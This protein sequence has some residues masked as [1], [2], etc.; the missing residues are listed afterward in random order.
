MHWSNQTGQLVQPAAVVIVA[1]APLQAAAYVGAILVRLRSN[2]RRVEDLGSSER[3]RLDWLR[4]LTLTFAV[5]LGL[6]LV[7]LGSFAIGHPLPPGSSRILYAGVAVVVYAWGYLGLRHSEVLAAPPDLVP[8]EPAP[9]L[10][11]SAVDL[12]RQPEKVMTPAEMTPRTVAPD[13][14]ETS[15]GGGQPVPVPG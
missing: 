9:A 5:V 10:A 11:N 12:P 3:M 2:R 14:G 15:L 13:S 8:P 4:D 1:T 7:Y 6:M